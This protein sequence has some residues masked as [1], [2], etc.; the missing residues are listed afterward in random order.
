MNLKE[1]NKPTRPFQCTLCTRTFSSMNYLKRHM[2]SHT[3]EKPHKC[4]YC[5]KRFASRSQLVQHQRIH[6]NERPYKCKE[7]DMAFRQ[8]GHLIQHSRAHNSRRL[9]IGVGYERTSDSKL[10]VCTVCDKSFSTNRWLKA[11][12]R[13]LHTGETPYKC[14][15]CC[16]EFP[17]HQK[18][19]YHLKSRHEE[20]KHECPD[21]GMRFSISWN[22]NSHRLL[23]SNSK[24][25]VC[26]ECDGR[27]VYAKDLKIH[28]LRH[29]DGPQTCHVCGQILSN[30]LR[31]KFHIGSHLLNK[32]FSCGECGK[33]FT[34]RAAVVH[35]FDGRHTQN[36]RR[37]S[38]SSSILNGSHRNSKLT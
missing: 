31:L 26:S 12:T 15:H 1:T 8:S 33:Q 18:Y 14:K 23:H 30:P 20:R 6:T 5:E 24:H 34:N 27:F 10:H 32:F 7:C 21:C 37:K 28:L 11:H 36:K 4:D 17:S 2:L 29:A 19:Y 3:N 35:H 38:N 9:P 22:L 13:I 25:Y 16:E